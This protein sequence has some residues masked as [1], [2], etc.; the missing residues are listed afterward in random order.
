M[1]S[2]EEAFRRMVRG[3]EAAFAELFDRH[4]GAVYRYSWGL[5]ESRDEV[6]DIVQETFLVLWR[7]RKEIRLAGH[8]VLPW[9][10]VCCRNTAYN[11]NRARRRSPAGELTEPKPGTHAWHRRVEQEQ[12]VEELAW[13]REEIAAL[14]DTERRL[15]DLCLIE[16]LSYDEAASA[17]GIS[18]SAAR[19]RIQRARG[20]LRAAKTANL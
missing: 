17:L 5:A 8:S 13:V 18:P 16:G 7:R 2:D 6:A 10:L 3:S 4:S 19:K 15:C 12:A 1:T 11:H 14:P 9:L 20:K